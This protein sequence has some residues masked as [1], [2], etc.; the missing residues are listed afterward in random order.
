MYSFQQFQND[1]LSLKDPD[2]DSKKVD[3]LEE[4]LYSLLIKQDEQNQ[5]FRVDT[6]TGETAVLA[7]RA[8]QNSQMQSF[9]AAIGK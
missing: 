9:W 6:V 2:V 1:L 3:L 7:F 5:L 8:V 4:L